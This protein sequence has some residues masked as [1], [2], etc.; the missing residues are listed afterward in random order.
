MISKRQAREL[1][2]FQFDKDLADFFGV[3]K[4]AVSAWPE[5]AP[6]P[7]GRQWQLRALRPDLWPA[8]QATPPPQAADQ[9]AA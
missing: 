1:L 9:K 7:E 2:G 3:G 8:T 4:G 5:D 6:L